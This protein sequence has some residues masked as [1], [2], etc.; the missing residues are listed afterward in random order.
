MLSSSAVV[1]LDLEHPSGRVVVAEL[2]HVAGGS[3]LFGRHGSCVVVGVG[4]GDTLVDRCT[5]QN[6]EQFDSCK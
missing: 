5:W 3:F 1:F 6:C 2:L 4:Y